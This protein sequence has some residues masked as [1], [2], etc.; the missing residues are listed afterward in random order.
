MAS[1]SSIGSNIDVE[2]ARNIASVGLEKGKVLA[3]QK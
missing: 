1:Y 2:D 3:A